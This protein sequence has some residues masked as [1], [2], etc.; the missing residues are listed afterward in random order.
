VT[1]TTLSQSLAT[2]PRPLVP[3]FCQASL[4]F[5]VCAAIILAAQIPADRH[6][7][8]PVAF[9]S[10]AWALFLVGVVLT[11]RVKFFAW[12]VLRL[13]ASRHCLVEVVI[14]G[15]LEFVFIH[16]HMRATILTIFTSLLVVFAMD[17]ALLI[18]FTVAQYQ[19]VD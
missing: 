4:G 16:D 19:S 18:A 3:L 7:A 1:S 2:P 13:V 14:G 11:T 6:L 12:R 15:M 8:L 9:D 17:V 5:L 10:T